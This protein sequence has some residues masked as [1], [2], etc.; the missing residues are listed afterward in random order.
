MAKP[1]IP[2]EW[3]RDYS[4]DKEEFES[5]LLEQHLLFKR[6]Y[7][8]IDRWEQNNYK[9]NLK[10]SNYESPS[11]GNLQADGVGYARALGEIK[12][13]LKFVKG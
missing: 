13:L 3:T 6:L 8:I 2:S 10:K 5:K 9:D 1:I 11:W 4:E 12:N 7:D